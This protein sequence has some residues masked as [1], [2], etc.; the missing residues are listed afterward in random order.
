MSEFVVVAFRSAGNRGKGGYG[1]EEQD[2]TANSHR[3]TSV[4]PGVGHP[5]PRWKPAIIDP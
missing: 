5:T 2:S 3:V 1:Y 4:T